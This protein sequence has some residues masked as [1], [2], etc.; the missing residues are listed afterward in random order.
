MYNFLNRYSYALAAVF[1]VL[2][3]AVVAYLWLPLP[4]GWLLAAALG[5]VFA[6][7][8]GILRIRTANPADVAELTA[9]VGAGRPVL[10]FLYANY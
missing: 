1:L 8:Y 10:V 7:A 9:L 5:I 6:A 4:G 3:S 2:V